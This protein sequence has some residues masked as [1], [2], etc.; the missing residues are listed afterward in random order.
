MDDYEPM[1]VMDPECET[2]IPESEMRADDDCYWECPGCG[3]PHFFM[4]D[5]SCGKCGWAGH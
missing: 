2:R 4:G 3:D 1:P 5:P